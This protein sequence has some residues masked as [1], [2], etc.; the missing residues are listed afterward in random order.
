MWMLW[1]LVLLLP[2]ASG[3][4]ESVGQAAEPVVP[5]ALEP[6]KGWVLHDVA[7]LGCPSPYDDARERLAVWPSG[8]SLDLKASEGRWTMPLEAFGRSWLP[9]PG[10][11]ETWPTSVT[12]N[13][14][15]VAV[16]AR[17]GVPSIRVEPGRHLVAGEF[18]W[19]RLPERLAIP[20]T[21]GIVELVR[22]GA[23]VALPE[24]D[25]EGWLWLERSRA[26]EEEQ[27]QLQVHLSRVL[28]DG[29]PIWLRTEI[30]LSVSGRSREEVIGQVLPVGWQLAAV[31]GPIPVAVDDVGQ[32][33]AQVRPGS[34]RIRIDAF[35][36][37][38]LSQLTYPEGTD[39]IAQEELVGLR[40]RPE[41][42]VIEFTDAVPVDVAMTRFP[43]QWR[44]LP[45][46]R[47]N[48]AQPLSWV[49]KDSGAGLRKPD[50]FEMTR[51]LWL[52]DD[53][54]G[55]TYE[56][57]IQGECRELSRLHA[58]A[59]NELAV[60]RIDGQRQLITT[61]P[62]SGAAGVELRA[63]RP[64]VEAIGRMTREPL[65]SA[66]GWQADADSLRV[67]LSL[68][69]GWRMLAVFGADRVEGDWL[70][71]WTLLDLFLLLVFSLAVFR[72]RGFVAGLVAFLAFGL[73]YHELY[74]PRFTWLFLLAPVALLAVVRSPRA[75]WWMQAW[76][77]LAI[78]L[79]L[80]HLIP[81]V[82]GEVQSTL[83][84][85]L[86]PGG[87][88]YRQRSL[89]E[90]FSGPRRAIPPG[91]VQLDVAVSTSSVSSSV[92]R[93][94]SRGGE[95]QAAEQQAGQ[96]K[97]VLFDSAN[98]Q[99]APGTTTQ[100]GIPRPAWQG[101]QVE[102]F[103]DGPVGQEQTLR[104][105]LLPA[106]GH[107][108]LAVVRVT[109]LGC[110]LGIFLRPPSPPRRKGPPR[111]SA[112]LAI[113]LLVAL[114]LSTDS[115][116]AQDAAQ[117]PPT[118]NEAPP[119]QGPTA[120]AEQAPPVSDVYPSTKMLSELRER[121]LQPDDAFPHAAE[122]PTAT[123]VITGNRLSLTATVHAAVDCAVPLPGKLP[124]WSPLSVVRD[125]EAASVVRRPDGYLWV[126][127]PAGVSDLAVEGRIPESAE[128]VLGFQLSP[129]RLELE[130]AEWI[131]SGVNPDGLVE[132]QLFFTRRQQQDA[133][134]A[135]YDQSNVRGVV[136]IDRVLEAGLVWKLHTTVRR[137][138]QPGRAISLTV[139]L[140][141]GERVL[142]GGTIGGNGTIDVALAA[143]AESY[144]WESELPAMPEIQL[145]AAASP[146]SVE[147][148]SLITSPVWNVS[149]TGAGPVY[150]ADAAELIPVWYP[151]PG[152][153]V[154][155]AF[156][157]PQALDGKS[158]TIRGLSRTDEFGARRRSS[159]IDL[160][161]ESSLGGEFFVGLPETATVR[162]VELE[163]RSLPV[164][165]EAGRVLVGLQPGRQ[166]LTLAWTTD[167]PL[168]RQTTFDPVELPVEAANVTSQMRL[169]E[170]R[171]ILWASGPLRG[172]AVRFWAVL[173]LA[174]VL[175]G[176]LS[177]PQLSPLKFHEW[178]L[179]L[180]G[181]TQIS[182]IP[183]AAVVGWLYLL[184]WRGQKD[185][186]GF[187]WFS[188][189]VLQLFLVGLTIG[190]LV[191]LVVVVS[192]GLL[193]T[194]EMFITGNGSAGS[195]LIWFS[196]AEGSELGQPWALSISI[197][198]YRLLM[199][200]WGLW[201]ANAVIRWLMAGWRQFTAGAAWRWRSRIAKEP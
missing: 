17:E 192:R 31:A 191:T 153:E 184:A 138:S 134:A 109:L 48:T 148:W 99:F 41:F 159:S 118:A 103:W 63:P 96:A 98:M 47:W 54:R 65:L 185:P 62:A 76:R 67:S 73:A 34:W 199:L 135:A 189:D 145:V 129:R 106:V 77:L 167:E 121:L 158:L 170:S 175:A 57:I 83:Y 97:Q 89:W 137:L 10:S 55:L 144:A 119:G 28:E 36:T 12:L 27:D 13:G 33:R 75:V 66:T 21:I 117:P 42:R 107:R 186:Q 147:R 44:T 165:R 51:R 90:I 174:V 196:P 149:L 166:Q 46:F 81:Y 25:A 140:V 39:S 35:R 2:L 195:Q 162:A 115:A 40:L 6:W 181:L 32:L 131:V 160:R 194:P 53:G 45:V 157:R 87:I 123:L 72:M 182:V 125:G 16:V 146:Q 52:D 132:E 156:A 164:R 18:R 105:L 70:T 139:P 130:A 20:A 120:A 172:P 154:T 150:E 102:C 141:A 68:P 26:A 88:H 136:Q 9:L 3:L 110:L 60:V 79:L 179:L 183:A 133:G 1:R 188:F 163:G 126:W 111:Q 108:I 86:E 101:N 58:I 116:K 128:W 152:E 15:P 7:N 78:G 100:T 14:E 151:W 29:L 173:A 155:L 50:R 82:T 193:G 143:N 38:D 95:P 84:P 113:A 74:A 19:S 4:I 112:G 169:P 104:P 85:Q 56:D 24:R 201:L 94:R 178:L 30:E 22:S 177:R 171:W 114:L 43:D 200:L 59:G 197:W 91:Q 127:V 61:D 11:A 8:L 161:L 23:A 142:S 168:A 122:I 80:M 187:G 176:G 92:S 190:S 37:E 71:A 69:P 124:V 198:Y 93:Y 180:I 49:V 64:R 5:R